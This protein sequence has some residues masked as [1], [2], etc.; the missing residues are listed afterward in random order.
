MRPKKVAFSLNPGRDPGNK[1]TARRRQ[2]PRNVGFAELKPYNLG[3]T[4]H[5]SKIPT[6]EGKSLGIECHAVTVDSIAL[7]TIQST[8]RPGVEIVILPQFIAQDVERFQSMPRWQLEV[9]IRSV[10]PKYQQTKGSPLPWWV[11]NRSP[12]NSK[13]PSSLTQLSWISLISSL[14]NKALV[15]N[16]YLV[17]RAAI[18]LWEAQE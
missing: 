9:V 10:D 1:E 8:S 2:P 13:C 15:V 7:S 5:V 14:Q 17:S 6:I 3:S 4:S 18:D 12:R 16:H 11:Q